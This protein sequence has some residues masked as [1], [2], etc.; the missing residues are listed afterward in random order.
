MFIARAELIVC[1]V[2]IIIRFKKL[3]VFHFIAKISSL[4]WLLKKR[5]R[6]R[7]RPYKLLQPA[8]VLIIVKEEMEQRLGD[9][10]RLLNR[11]TAIKNLNLQLLKDKIEQ[12]AASSSTTNYVEIKF[13]DSPGLTSILS[14][15]QGKT[16][17]LVESFWRAWGGLE[18]LKVE[19]AG[20]SGLKF[21]WEGVPEC[22]VDQE[23]QYRKFL[24]QCT[25][26]VEVGQKRQRT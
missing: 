17:A 7:K 18:S 10:L 3:W 5:S 9:K 15:E 19:A 11:F 22:T 25:A 23:E 8:P 13:N 2:Q 16:N 4:T 14:L 20:S 12:E 26:S 6:S 1:Q 21:S 24:D